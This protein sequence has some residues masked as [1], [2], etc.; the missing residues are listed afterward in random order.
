MIRF[1]NHNSFEIKDINYICYHFAESGK[2]VDTSKGTR[3]IAIDPKSHM[4]RK[5]NLGFVHTQTAWIKCE[6]TGFSL[7]R[8]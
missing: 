7:I 5:I 3:Y 1:E 6:C 4:Y 2:V 8:N